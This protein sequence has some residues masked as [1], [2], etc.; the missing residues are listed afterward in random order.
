MG[1]VF[2]DDMTYQVPDTHYVTE[3]VSWSAFEDDPEKAFDL[4]LGD[5]TR[6]AGLEL[7]DVVN[8]PTEEGSLLVVFRNPSGKR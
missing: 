4:W 8:H 7:V 1:K 2:N 6:V 3:T 5:R